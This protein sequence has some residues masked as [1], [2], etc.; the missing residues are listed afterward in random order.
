MGYSIASSAPYLTNAC[1][2]DF[3]SPA[4]LDPSDDIGL[5]HVLETCH[6]VLA[7]IVLVNDTNYFVLALTQPALLKVM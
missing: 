7:R 3:V 2:E 6:I 5:R 4:A 1:I